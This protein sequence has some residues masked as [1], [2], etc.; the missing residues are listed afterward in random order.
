M[1]TLRI[2]TIQTSLHWEATS[3]NLAH[4]SN[5]ILP[6]KGKTDLVILPETFTTGFS[7]QPEPIAEHFP[8]SSVEWM[9]EQAASVGA[10][11]TG[12]IVSKVGEEYFNRLVW[13][14]PDG[15][16]EV[17]DKRHLFGYAGEDTH[18]KAGT[19]RLLVSIG[20]WS[21]CPMICYD[22]RFPVWSRN[23]VDGYDLLI[24]IANWPSP[25]RT[26]WK[27][28]LQA[29]AIENLSYVAGVNRIGTDANGFTYMGDS[30]VIDFLGDVIDMAPESQEAVRT[31]QLDKKALNDYRARF[32]FLDDADPFEL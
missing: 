10:V 7:M 20:D 8:G 19:E 15:H 26:A 11:V 24:Y 6:L 23:N 16:Y 29:R 4:F 18:F 2:S 14:P 27:K 25:R 31:H 9:A 5:L 32:P 21:I 1:S 17:Y 12:S 13:M 30:C 28:L 22:L 3:Q